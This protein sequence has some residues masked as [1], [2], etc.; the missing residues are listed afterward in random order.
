MSEAVKPNKAHEST[1]KY[2][3]PPSESLNSFERVSQI[4]AGF[5]RAWD[6][7]RPDLVEWLSLVIGE[8]RASL[9]RNLLEID[10]RCRRRS[11]ESPSALDYVVRLPDEEKLIRRVF[12]DASSLSISAIHDQTPGETFIPGPP[13]ARL[14]EYRL[15]RELGRGGMGAV[16]EAVHMRHGYRVA[17]KTLPA[18]SGES[19]HRFKREFR[20]LAD[21]VHPNL[22][23]LRTLE[24]DG[25]QWFITL[26]L[27]EGLDFLSY[28]R[29]NDRLDATRLRA[30]FG[31]LVTGLM[32]L[33][34]RGVVHRDL[35]PGN[36]LVTGAGRVVILDF[37]LVADWKQSAGVSSA[38]IAGTPAYMAPEQAGA[39]QIGP[40]AD[41]YAV[42]V[43]LYEAISGHRPFSGDIWEMIADK[44]RRDAPPIAE[45]PG[46]PAELASLAMKMLSRE[47]ADRPSLLDVVGAVANSAQ[48]VMGQRSGS[49]SLVGR[50][51]QVAMMQKVLASFRH[52]KT[53]LTLFIR[54][55]SGEGKTSLAEHFLAPL[56]EQNSMVI[57]SG[58][59]YDRESVPF[60]ALD[61]LID[62]L[63]AY[64]RSQTESEAALLLP[65]DISFLA[66]LFPVLR[67]CEVVARAHRGRTNV[68]DQQQIR[69]R[70]FGALRLMLDRISTKTPIIWFI[71]DLQW[72]DVDSASALF[73]VLRPPDAPHV[74]FLGSFRSDEADNSP[75]LGEWSSQQQ[76]CGID[77][78]DQF[79]NV[80][81]LSLEDS[82][83]LVVNLL[84]RDDEV[85]KRRSVQFHAQ[86]GGNPFL[87]TELA[88]CFDPNLDEFH[89][90][91]IH[92]VLKKKL[93][94]LPDEAVPLL[95]VV[96]AAGQAIELQEAAIASRVKD[97]VEDVLTRMRNLRV[98]RVVG[99]KI[100][101]YH[102]RVRYAILDRLDEGLKKEIHLNLAEVIEHTTGGLESAVVDAIAAGQSPEKW[103]DS[104][105]RVYDLAYHFDA[106]GESRRA[107]VYGFLAA[108]QARSRFAIDV[109]AQ[110]Y[111]LAQRHAQ[112]AVE[113]VQYQLARG[114][115]EALIEMGVY[116]DAKRQLNE[117]TRLAT[118]PIE[119]A[120]TSG[121]HGELASRLGLVGE[122]ISHFEQG[123]QILGTPIPKSMLGK[124]WGILKE[125]SIQ[126][127]HCW[128]PSQLHRSLP[129]AA[130]DL[131]NYLL[132]RLEWSL[133]C[134]NVVY[135]V[136]AS[137]L[138]LNRAE[139]LPKSKALAINYVVHA[140]DMAVLGWHRRAEKYYRK[141]IELSN[142]I[143]DQWCAAIGQ[144]HSC[145]GHMAAG[146]YRDAIE[147]AELAKTALEN[148]RDMRTL[149][150]AYVFTIMGN[151]SLGNLREA[152][153][154]SRWL[155]DSYVRHGD[156]Y[157]A[158]WTV[159]SLARC[160]RGRIPVDELLQCVSA[161]PGNNLSA[162]ALL[163][164]EAH[165]H[166]FHGRTAMALDASEKAWG[167]CV[168]NVYL[169]TFNTNVLCHLVTSLRLH[170]EA[171]EK[172]GDVAAT[173]VR[174]RFSKLARRAYRLSWFL[175]PE[176]P[177]ALR[178][179]SLVYVHRGK[180]SA[181][182]RLAVA[183]CRAAEGMEARYEYAQSLLVMGR[184]SKQLNMPEADSQISKAQDIIQEIEAAV[185]SE[186]TAGCGPPTAII[187]P[188]AD[189]TLAG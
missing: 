156:Q 76:K 181:A 151:Y 130:S 62:A 58:R 111:A 145:I 28:V 25:G 166:S 175:P 54:G 24:S 104:L 64:L 141:T 13:A 80:G 14:G 136:W 65:D 125:A 122:S 48:V 78:H 83:R 101:T 37:G 7:G 56:R 27:L 182:L 68:V 109:A 71:D 170:A 16:F 77:L 129:N 73:E 9:L 148:V 113:S 82:T 69:Q 139:R 183:S 161:L 46:I 115:G 188:A 189:G 2:F 184:I 159:Y 36:V 176:R 165:W 87:L 12:L 150:G 19:L 60:K 99:A 102:D 146:R 147:T 86:T 112:F 121:L 98:L 50:E 32:A 42:G 92:D 38:G 97:S 31:Q 149:R 117:A 67:R 132:A 124:C 52:Q 84:E 178:E 34:S 131:T 107:L 40:Q 63:A 44:Q 126:V 164:A 171:L 21:V 169:V 95:N 154:I 120:D 108:R 172:L 144:S 30:C 57:M 3:V 53:P 135:L 157:F 91:D 29:P 18:V 143:N 110:Q 106:A 133:F 127:M 185:D 134:H 23:G 74:L 180:L 100:D 72:G 75:F 43:M 93:A 168:Q 186:L 160:T 96:S 85:V 45:I 137:L 119:I 35:K 26:D 174:R 4:C 128:R 158:V 88:G 22:V 173:S 6:E 94:Q 51:S 187:E 33:H 10:I 49:D 105:P 123:I 66:E 5:R 162:T 138:G 59:C 11:G 140:N 55:R 47:P 153:R 90:S 155:F 61:T 81:P 152:F 70:A 8:E 177:H 142:E 20:V 41:W 114:H 1:V 118:K 103:K 179:L 167:I 163:M 15:V 17:I 39:K 116:D 89:A 79:I